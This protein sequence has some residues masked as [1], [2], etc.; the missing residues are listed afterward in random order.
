MKGTAAKFNHRINRKNKIRL[1]YVAICV[2][3]SSGFSSRLG[4][5]SFMWVLAIRRDSSSIKS[6]K[7]A[8]RSCDVYGSKRDGWVKV[9]FRGCEWGNSTRQIGL[10]DLMFQMPEMRDQAVK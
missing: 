10:G 7:A 3:G 2:G 1:H 4:F 9:G 5:C 8:S 6:F